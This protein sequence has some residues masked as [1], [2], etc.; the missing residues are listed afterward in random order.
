MK[1]CRTVDQP[2]KIPR[3]TIPSGRESKSRWRECG[4]GARACGQGVTVFCSADARPTRS[5]REEA[6][7]VSD[8]SRA[9]STPPCDSACCVKTQ[10]V[11]VTLVHRLGYGATQISWS[12]DRL[13]LAVH[14]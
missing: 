5:N 9:S 1:S 7:R 4:I 2:G 6:A 13:V 3:A 8:A 11:P 10:T 12:V 14:G